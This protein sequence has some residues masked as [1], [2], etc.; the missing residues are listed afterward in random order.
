MSTDSA[1]HRPW[2]AVARRN[3]RQSEIV[4]PP[5]YLASAQSQTGG[6]VPTLADTISRYVDC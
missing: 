5:L 6:A 4:S 3:H 1:D 2:L